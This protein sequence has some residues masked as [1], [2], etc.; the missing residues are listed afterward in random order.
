MY[1]VSF[2]STVCRNPLPDKYAEPWCYTEAEY[3]S[4]TYTTTAI[5]REVCG[6]DICPDEDTDDTK[7]ET[8]GET[9]ERQKSRKN[10]L[11]YLPEGLFFCWLL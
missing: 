2:E 9:G 5:R 7:D 6:I 8:D 3:D 4:Q 1:G 11:A 10:T